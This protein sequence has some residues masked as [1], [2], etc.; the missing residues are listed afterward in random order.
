MQGVWVQYLV[1]EL[2]TCLRAKKPKHRNNII[3]NSIKIL[4][5]VHIKKIFLICL[6][7][8]CCPANKFK[9]TIFLDSIY[10]HYIQYLFFSFWLTSLCI[11]GSRFT[12]LIR[13]DSHA[14]F[15][16]LSNI[17]LYIRNTVEEEEGGWMERV[18]GNIY[19]ATCKTAVGICCITQGA[20]T[21]CSVTTQRV[22]MG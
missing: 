19:I 16:R 11:I 1:R 21:Q 4:K 5:I 20:Q 18:A 2:R 6:H 15:L 10:M 14:L 9:S 22:G 8:H 3:I 17:P 13:T 7:L 12:H